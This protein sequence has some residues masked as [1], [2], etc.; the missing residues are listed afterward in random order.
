MYM[1]ITDVSVLILKSTAGKKGKYRIGLL[2]AGKSMTVTLLVSVRGYLKHTN[3]FIW[4][5]K[6]M[7]FYFRQIYIS[8]LLPNL[9][10]LCSM[11]DVQVLRLRVA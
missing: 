11:M 10:I 8:M 2:M 6:L 5:E 7:V 3:S 1:P 4:V 9:N